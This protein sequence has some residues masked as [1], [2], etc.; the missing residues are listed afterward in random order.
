MSSLNPFSLTPIVRRV[1][2]NQLQCIMDELFKILSENKNERRDIAG[3]GL[4]TVVLELSADSSSAVIAINK[5][6]PRLLTQL[7]SVIIYK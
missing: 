1:R 7:K 4:K 5:L 3:L 2:E 6:I